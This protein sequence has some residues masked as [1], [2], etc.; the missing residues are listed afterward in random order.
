[1]FTRLQ[2]PATTPTALR[3]LA[4]IE[5]SENAPQIAWR[6]DETWQPWHDGGGYGQRFGPL[7]KPPPPVDQPAL[8]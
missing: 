5:C 4:H 8:F 2:L 3:V 6:H 1:V 7:P